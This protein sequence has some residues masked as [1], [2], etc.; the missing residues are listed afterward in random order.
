MDTCKKAEKI[1]GTIVSD[2]IFCFFCF[3]STTLQLINRLKH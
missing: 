1:M 2:F 3:S